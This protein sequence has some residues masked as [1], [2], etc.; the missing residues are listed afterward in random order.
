[1]ITLKKK[2]KDM[3]FTPYDYT[4]EKMDKFYSIVPY[5]L[6][7]IDGE[8]HIAILEP[9]FDEM[10]TLIDSSIVPK[11]LN[12]TIIVDKKVMEQLYLYHPEMEKPEK[13][14]WE[15]YMDLLKTFEGSM[16]DKVMRELYYRAGPTEKALQEALG[17]LSKYP[18]VTMQI[19]NKHFLKVNR[20]FA[21]RVVQ[22]FLMGWHAQAYKALSI[23]ITEIGSKAAFYAM[24]KYIRTVYKEKV[25]YLNNEETKE[26]I[27]TKADSYTI[28][29]LYTL[30]EE[31]TN[32][33]Q[34]YIILHIF[35]EGKICL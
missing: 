35:E 12:V 4:F 33:Y 15:K 24:R 19:L 18:V 8:W 9:K 16:E 13:T 3:Q 14:N 30:F 23:L 28:V 2:Q 34:L 20:V 25:K 1:M 10:L 26:W 31:A 11:H 21:S 22:Q 27:V 6:P 32:P 5:L 17:L 29:R 7:K